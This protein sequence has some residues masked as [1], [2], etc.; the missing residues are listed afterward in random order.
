VNT[1]RIAAEL[2]NMALTPGV[3][4][5]ALVDTV[6]GMVYLSA[7]SHPQIDSVAE[8]ASDYW[9]M[10][11]RNGIPCVNMGALQ[12][13]SIIHQDGVLI[14]MPCGTGIVM[15]TM[16]GRMQLD[17]G[18]WFRKVGHLGLMVCER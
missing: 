11:E 17:L 16:C 4:A 18:A 15:A 3:R 2:A 12:A 13:I 10:H 8:V 5:C 9:R 14:L 6:T 7:G 1:Q